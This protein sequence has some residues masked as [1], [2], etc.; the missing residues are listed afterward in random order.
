MNTEIVS[1]YHLRAKEYE[2]IYL[3]PERQKD[4]QQLS[5][6][7]QEIFK[8][9][10]VFEIACG[11]G[12]WTERIATTAKRVFATDINDAVLEIVKAKAYS[13]EVSFERKDIFHLKEERKYAS[14]F[15]G[16]IWSHIQKQ[17]LTAFI[18]G[19]N[20]LVEED[21]RSC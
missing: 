11:T 8:D 6:L 4:L 16:F 2:N 10:D 14:V 13:T 7:L 15:G 20:K 17:A 19:I 1:Y 21:G 3:K 12:Y 5:K 9:K 18:N